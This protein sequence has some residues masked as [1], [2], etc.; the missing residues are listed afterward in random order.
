MN[1]LLEEMANITLNVLMML[2]LL[3]VGIKNLFGGSVIIV[4]G[5]SYFSRL[6]SKKKVEL[7]VSYKPNLS[8]FCMLSGYQDTLPKI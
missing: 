5:N 7:T 6:G 8:N 2:F 4:L 3:M 1:T